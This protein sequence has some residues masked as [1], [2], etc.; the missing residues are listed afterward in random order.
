M[1]VANYFNVHFES[2]HS[3]YEVVARW[4]QNRDGTFEVQYR[5]SAVVSG[6]P[7]S[8]DNGELAYANRRSYLKTVGITVEYNGTTVDAQASGETSL[9][10]QELV[11]EDYE[12]NG[13]LKSFGLAIGVI[14]LLVVIAHI[15]YLIAQWEHNIM[16][17]S[18]RW[19][20]LGMCV[21]VVLLFLYVCVSYAAPSKATCTAAVWLSHMGFVFTVSSLTVKTWRVMVLASNPDKLNNKKDVQRV[22]K[23]AMWILLT[24]TLATVSYLAIWT[25]RY[26][27]YD[28]EVKQLQQSPYSRRHC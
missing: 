8:I 20:L 24:I 22:D 6:D 10:R 13:R 28:Q 23:H 4:L 3:K 18:Q 12:S 26:P 21:G 9:A 19:Y 25:V 2:G 14:G 17:L 1:S 5:P 7:H 16:K 11:I 15:A 27:S